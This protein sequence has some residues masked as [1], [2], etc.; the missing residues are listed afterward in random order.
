MN[1]IITVTRRK[2]PPQPVKT[3]DDDVCLHTFTCKSSR[4]GSD[5]KPLSGNRLRLKGFL[6]FI[7]SF[8]DPL[9]GTEYMICSGPDLK[10]SPADY[11]EQVGKHMAIVMHTPGGYL[12]AGPERAT[13]KRR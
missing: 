3:A 2:V 8:V 10:K 5:D 6:S 9:A 12:V 13:A 4:K 11:F 1:A 7:D